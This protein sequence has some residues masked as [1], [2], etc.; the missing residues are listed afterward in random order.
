MGE[1]TGVFRVAQWSLKYESVCEHDEDVLA[2]LL[3]HVREKQP[4][5]LSARSWSVRYGSHLATPGRLWM[6]E[7]ASLAA[8]ETA[9]TKEFTPAC[10]RI[11]DR[12]RS[13]AVSASYSTSVWT[14]NHRKFWK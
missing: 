13:H 14:D 1:A 10:T 11:W 3:E 2:K 12:V 7:F 4:S 5:V 9:D 8:M 6:E